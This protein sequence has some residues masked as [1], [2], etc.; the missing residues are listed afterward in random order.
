[1]GRILGFAVLAGAEVGAAAGAPFTLFGATIGMAVG[2][3]LGLLSGVVT[4]LLWP[5]SR[6]P[7]VAEARLLVMA[8]PQFLLVGAATAAGLLGA[9]RQ[10]GPATTLIAGIAVVVALPLTAVLTWCAA[11]WLRLASVVDPEAEAQAWR[12][13]RRAVLAPVWVIVLASLGYLPFI[14]T[15]L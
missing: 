6:V 2:A 1:M 14:V 12:R 4:V 10:A 9:F 5:R 8:P 3:V 13:T 7:D 11:P 15:G